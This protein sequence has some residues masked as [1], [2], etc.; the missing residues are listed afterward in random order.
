M[1]HFVACHDALVYLTSTFLDANIASACADVGITWDSV[2]FAPG[3]GRFLAEDVETGDLLMNTDLKLPAL[4]VYMET[5]VNSNYTLGNAFAGAV[6]FCLDLHIAANEKMNDQIYLMKYKYA[7]VQGMFVTIDGSN[8]A[9]PQAWVTYKVAYSRGMSFEMGPSG[10]F[11]SNQFA[12]YQG[13]DI[14]LAKLK[15][16]AKFNLIRAV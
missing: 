5:A 11:S 9:I 13:A 6:N 1:S 16:K 14:W 10:L 2:N 4:S 8:P 12:D 3:N 7:V 15:F